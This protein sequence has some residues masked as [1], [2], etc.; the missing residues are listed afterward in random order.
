MSEI[1]EVLSEDEAYLWA[2]L[3]DESGL[4]Q[5]EF[6]WFDYENEEDNCWRAW[7][8]QWPW[9]RDDS[10][11]QIDQSARSVGKSMSIKIRAYAFPFVHPGQE[12]LVTAPE[13][14][15]L[16]AITNLIEKTFLT[17]RMGREMLVKKNNGITHKPFEMSFRNDSRIMGRIPHRDGAGVKGVHPIWVEHDEACFPGD[18]LI[19]TDRGHVPISDVIVGDLVFTHLNRWKPVINV[20]DKG[21]RET[22]QIKGQG[23]P[24]LR[25]TP[26]HRF[27]ASVVTG[28]KS[29]S[30]KWGVKERAKLDW[31]EA[32]RLAGEAFWASPLNV[33]TIKAP[34]VIPKAKTGASTEIAV[35]TPAFMWCLG[36]Y[37]AEGSTSNSGA[38]VRNNK[39][40][41]SVHTKEVPHVVETLRVAGLRPFVQP[42]QN[43]LNCRN[44]VVASVELAAFV[45][46]YCGTG[47]YDKKIPVWVHGLSEQLRRAYLDGL[48]YGDG[49]MCSDIRYA[50]G[51]WKLATT[52]RALA[53]DT[54]LLAQSLGFYV[55]VH[56]NEGGQVHS[57]RGRSFVSSRNYQVVGGTVG[58]GFDEDNFRLT[59]VK[60]AIDVGYTRVYDVEVEDDHSFVA[61]GIVVHNSDY[62]AAGWVELI[63]TMKRG[64][65]GA[66]WRV[67]GVTRGVRDYFYRFTQSPEWKVHRVTSM[68][69]PPPFWSDEERQQK[70]EEYT[71]KDHPDYR[72]NILGM[73]GDASNPLFVLHRL[74][75]CVDSDD[76]SEYN[77]DVYQ[78]TKLTAE[79]LDDLG[80]EID[81]ALRLNEKHLQGYSGYWVGQDVG[82]LNHPSEIVVFGEKRDVKK[83]SKL[84]LLTRIKLERLSHNKQVDVI[85]K[86]MDFYSP[87]AY[88]M[89]S[90]GI[91]LPLFQDLQERRPELAHKI[92]AYNFS[93][94]IIVDFDS[95]V[96]VD[97]FYGD[98]AKEAGILRNVLEYSSDKLRE[99]VDLQRIELPLHKE[100]IEEFCGQTWSVSKSKMDQYGRTR[101]FSKGMFHCLDAC[102]MAV[103]GY[104]QHGI[105][106]YMK[107]EKFEGTTD[108]FLTF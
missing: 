76:E 103:L 57:I 89:D 3:S 17:N 47:C 73:H 11:R 34:L 82:Y 33:A 105:E 58:Q 51:R 19:L 14:I 23:H 107:K 49:N 92:K 70:I 25:V 65:K 44:V 45:D 86:I 99:L 88:S 56:Q 1:L 48:I 72:R 104:A 29:P 95:T 6:S 64:S 10:M 20:F 97:D 22:I 37:A 66:H 38:T 27:W 61:E 81:I 28:W 67:H 79:S 87:N 7:P 69:R 100:L 77:T 31:V 26:N 5:A 54:R 12:M 55:N 32:D 71:S 96:E 36:L 52:S 94:K 16:S 84:V 108:V 98:K 4:D 75:A 21:L 93:Q 2:I 8:Y 83:G 43:T 41:W 35:L 30:K 24:G 50:A 91:G 60:S 53:F 9:F 85:F 42:V 90:T 40:T 13:G 18:T 80:G 39:V 106:A 78:Y 74:M 68:H 46:E 62:P 101:D 59:K 63:E 15:H 102:K